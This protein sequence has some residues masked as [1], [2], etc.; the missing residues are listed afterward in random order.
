MTQFGNVVVL[1]LSLPLPSVVGGVVDIR[2][3]PTYIDLTTD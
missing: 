3:T 1:L 2:Y